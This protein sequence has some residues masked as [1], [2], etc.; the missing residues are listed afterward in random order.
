MDN[1]LLNLQYDEVGRLAELGLLDDEL[2]KIYDY[3]K[4]GSIGSLYIIGS[5]LTYLP[6]WL[7]KVDG[8]LDITDSDIEDIPD[9]LVLLRGIYADNSNLKEFRRTHVFGDLS[10]EYTKITKLPNNLKVHA[11]LSVEG[12]QFEQFPK[13]L[14][15]GGSFY[16]HK[17]NLLQFSDTELYEMYNINGHIYRS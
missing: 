8:I 16:I 17:S 14:E 2:Y 13:N 4:N 1:E 12:I 11:Y 5:A 7:T 3:V 6:N 10:L 9:S 15:I